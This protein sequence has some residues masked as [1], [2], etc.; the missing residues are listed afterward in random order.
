MTQIEKKQLSLKFFLELL[1]I[2]VLFGS[3]YGTYRVNEYRVGHIERDFEKHCVVSGEN[4]KTITTEIKD[5]GKNQ[6]EILT[7]LREER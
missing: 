1:S 5:L 4:I 6:T 3:M 2:V 7:I